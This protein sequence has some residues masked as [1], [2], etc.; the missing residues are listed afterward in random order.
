MK[1]NIS[2]L[3]LF[4][5]ISNLWLACDNKESQVTE[6]VDPD[7]YNLG[8]TYH[9]YR[10][11]AEAGDNRTQED[12]SMMAEE[13]EMISEPEDETEVVSEPNDESEMADPSRF[14]SEL[15]RGNITELESG[16]YFLTICNFFMFVLH[17]SF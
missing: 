13:T 9:D 15:P 16:L 17:L 8:D 11:C 14:Y 12:S 5:I 3:I 2:C 10:S 7:P 4:G 6:T 1:L